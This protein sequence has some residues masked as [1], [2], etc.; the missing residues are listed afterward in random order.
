MT[1]RQ[2]TKL[3]N[4][5]AT[6]KYK[7]E[8]GRLLYEVL[9][10]E[11]KTFRQRRRTSKGWRYQLDNV[12]RVP[13]RLP[14]LLEARA[15]PFGDCEL[16]IVEG[17]KDVE[18]LVKRGEVATCNSEGA[19]HWKEKFDKWNWAPFFQGMVSLSSPTGTIKDI[20]TPSRSTVHLK[21]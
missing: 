8:R 5:V 19:G 16:W 6:Y 4:P 21:A 20:G 12:R 3:G 2:G 1:S 11:P 18:A 17:E 14:E 9:R 15:D 10:Y 7:D 13:Y